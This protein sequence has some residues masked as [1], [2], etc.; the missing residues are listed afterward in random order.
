MT[1]AELLAAVVAEREHI[2]G[3]HDCPMLTVEERASVAMASSFLKIVIDRFNVNNE[4]FNAE[5]TARK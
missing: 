5:G 4:K 1:R 3:L 2:R